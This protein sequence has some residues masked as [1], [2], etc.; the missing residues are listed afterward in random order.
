MLP[1]ET[2]KTIIKSTPLV[3]IDLIVRNPEGNVLLGKRTNRPAQGFWFVP[4]GRILK[5]ESFEQAFNR[6]VNIELGLS[7]QQVTFLG[8]Y[9]HFYEDNFS[10]DAFSTHYVVLAY[11]MNVMLDIGSLPIEQHNEYRWFNEEEILTSDSVHKHTKWYFQ[12]NKQSDVNC[13]KP[14]K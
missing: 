12:V 9:Q 4:G 6:L 3:S 1:T 11:E 13:L 10:T 7:N 14:N 2:F 5:D 8:T